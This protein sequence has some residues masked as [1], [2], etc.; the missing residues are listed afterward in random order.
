MYK[1]QDRTGAA[2]VEVGR[3][4]DAGTNRCHLG[5]MIG[6]DDGGHQVAAKRRTRLLDVYKRQNE[7][8]HPGYVAKRMEVGAVV[9]ATPANHVRRECPAPT[10][11]IIRCV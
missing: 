8:Y 6:A 1:R 9:G 11:K 2:V 4:K 10:D 3:L 7:L 5:T